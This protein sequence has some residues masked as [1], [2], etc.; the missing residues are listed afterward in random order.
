MRDSIGLENQFDVFVKV[1]QDAISCLHLFRPY[2]LL[3]GTSRKALRDIHTNI[4][5]TTKQ[6]IRISYAHVLSLEVVALVIKNH[7]FGQEVFLPQ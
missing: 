1:M 3:L 6:F 2:I 5:L 7:E 4:C